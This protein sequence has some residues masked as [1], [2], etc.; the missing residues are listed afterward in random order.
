M[1]RWWRGRGDSDPE[2]FSDTLIHSEQLST[3]QISAYELCQV[4]TEVLNFLQE[5][6]CHVLIKLM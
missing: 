2:V 4:L 3:L 5:E 1:N 6:M